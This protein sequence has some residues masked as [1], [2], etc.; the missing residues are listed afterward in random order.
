MLE[1]QTRKLNQALSVLG[2]IGAQYKVI[3]PDG[4]E[5]GE[6]EV[7]AIRP[8]ET[9]AGLPRYKRMETRS[10]FAPHLAEMKAGQVKV[11]ECGEYD[12]RVIARDIASYVANTMGSGVVSCLT[13][14]KSGTVQ[15]FA[16]K[17]L[18]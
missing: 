10:V 14:R 5:Y 13:L 11:I 1:V 6:L 2:L 12:P 8:K 16:Y 7:K 18:G 4:A 17:N 3:T 9:A 15:V